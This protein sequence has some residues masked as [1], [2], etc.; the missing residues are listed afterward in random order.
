[1]RVRR[2]LIAALVSA[3]PVHAEQA[4]STVSGRR[5]ARPETVEPPIGSRLG[6]RL[7]KVALTPVQIAEISHSAAACWVKQRRKASFEAATGA[8][9]EVRDAGFRTLERETPCSSM[10]MNGLVERAQWSLPIDIKS[11]ILAEHLLDPREMGELA[12]RPLQKSYERSWFGLSGRNIVVDEMAA[13]V[14]DTNPIGIRD[15]VRTRPESSEEKAALTA[16]SSSFGP[17]LRVGAKLQANRTGLRAALAE[18]LLQRIQ[19]PAPSPVA[20]VQQ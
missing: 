18:A 2:A 8:T 11:G 17:C 15:L 5:G 16:L 14:A 20:G 10:A 3:T 9:A 4:E 12:P 7:T 13:C 19:Q 1:M 6:N